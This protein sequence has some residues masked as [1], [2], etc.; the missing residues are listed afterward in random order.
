[1]Y[2]VYK[3]LDKKITIEEFASY[4]NNEFSGIGFNL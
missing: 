2:Q 4:F 1:M 3:I